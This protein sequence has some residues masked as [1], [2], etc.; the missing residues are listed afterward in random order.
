MCNAADSGMKNTPLLETHKKLGARIVGFAGWNMPAQYTNIIDEHITTRTK[1]GLFDICHMGEIIASGKDVR[2][3]IRKV[4]TR[5]MESLEENRAKY[6]LMCN[7][8]GNV[9]DDVFLYRFASNKYMMVVNACNTKKD[10]EWLK[11]NSK[12]LEVDI[13]DVSDKTGKLD[14]QGPLSKAV[15]EKASGDNAPERFCHKETNIEGVQVIISGTGYTG[16][17]GYEVYT[18]WEDT[19]KV[20]NSIIKIGRDYG[21]KPIGLGARDTLR[22]ESCYS[23]YGHDINENTTPVEAGLSWTADS[24]YEYIGKPVISK[25]KEFGTEMKLAAF[26][27]TDNSIPREKYE[28]VCENEAIGKVVSGTYSPTFKKGI[29]IAMIKRIHAKVD[30]AISINIRNTVHRAKIVKRPFYHYNGGNVK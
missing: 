3:L 29:G 22:L 2:K 5:D 19:E 13:N 4:M 15:I 14:V 17:Q 16:E 26:E 6:S 30:S 1:V 23:L 21:I 18:P 25:Q 28:V 24:K 10:F 27:M 7:E 20:W 9:V 11:L 12:G 8:K